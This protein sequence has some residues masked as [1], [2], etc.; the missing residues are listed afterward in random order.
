MHVQSCLTLCDPM[1][2]WTAAHQP[3][4]PWDFPGSNTGA[5]CFLLVQGIFLTQGSNQRLLQLLYWE[6]N[7]LPLT[8]PGKSRFL[9]TFNID[10]FI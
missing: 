10:Y 2:S 1:D 5:G 7:S 4:C 9:D 8:L 6:A 3:L